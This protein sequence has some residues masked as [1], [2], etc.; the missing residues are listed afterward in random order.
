MDLKDFYKNLGLTEGEKD[1]CPFYKECKRSVGNAELLSPVGAYIGNNYKEKGILVVGLN[2]NQAEGIDFFNRWYITHWII[3]LMKDKGIRN[4]E[5]VK[6]PVA[7][8]LN[9]EPLFR[10]LPRLVNKFLDR[11]FEEDSLFRVYDLI[12]FTNIVKCSTS[13]ERGAATKKMWENCI[14]P[15]QTQYIKRE[16]ETLRPS[17]VISIG[18]EPYWHIKNLFEKHDQKENIESVR[19]GFDDYL[20]KINSKGFSFYLI[21]SFHLSNPIQANKL[22]KQYRNSN[23]KSLKIFF[24]DNSSIPGSL[25]ELIKRYED[26]K[27]IIKNNYLFE[28]MM[29]KIASVVK[30]E[31]KG[32]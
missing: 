22:Y 26:N 7:Y 32:K 24:E 31:L 28:Y 21:K 9:S 25:Q 17:V 4:S 18:T 3:P 13:A 14:Y 27:L 20:L 11:P 16:I 12:S 19:K 1:F 15:E 23:L 30:E 10:D 29:D 8:A 6:L 2:T 5:G